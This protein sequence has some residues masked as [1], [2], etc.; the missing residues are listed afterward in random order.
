VLAEVTAREIGRVTIAEALELTA[1]VTRKA[2]SPLQPLRRPLAL[3]LAR[4]A[5]AGDARRCRAARLEPTSA[6]DRKGPRLGARDPEEVRTARLT[7]APTGWTRLRRPLASRGEEME[8]ALEVESP[9]AS[10][11]P[12]DKW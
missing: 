4:R 7:S 9:L 6:R 10:A 8:A 11:A 2:T 12:G 5:R 1:L 3:A